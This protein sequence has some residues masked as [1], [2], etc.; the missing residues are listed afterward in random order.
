MPL[1]HGEGADERDWAALY[2]RAYDWLRRHHP[3]SPAD[4]GDMAQQ[5]VLKVLVAYQ[6]GNAPRAE[7]QFDGWFAQ[8]IQNV[9]IDRERA[10]SGRQKQGKRTFVSWQEE[11]DAPD[12]RSEAQRDR[13][14]SQ[15]DVQALLVP[16]PPG[17]VRGAFILSAGYEFTSQ[18]LAFVFGVADSTVRGWMTSA[19]EK[20]RDAGGLA[21]PRASTPRAAASPPPRSRGRTRRTP[22]G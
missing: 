4:Y 16:L 11:R 14:E 5:A 17:V 21:T 10:E 3:R 2:Q 15:H 9:V 22:G 20:L 7:R 18:E 19:R 12:T 1:G 6:K 8:L 13:V